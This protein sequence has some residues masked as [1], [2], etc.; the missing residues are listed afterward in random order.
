MMAC[1]AT[2]PPMVT[3]RSGLPDDFPLG[4]LLICRAPLAAG[5][6][7]FDVAIGAAT[8]LV[9]GTWFPAADWLALGL[10]P[11]QPCL[12]PLRTPGGLLPRQ[13]G[14]YADQQLADLGRAG[15]QPIFLMAPDVDLMFA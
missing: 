12:D 14:K 9:P 4:A 6:P 11:G 8:R 2:S 13:P 10:A 3:V 5:L 15:P 1:Q 7:G